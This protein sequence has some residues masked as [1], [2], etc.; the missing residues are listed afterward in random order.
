MTRRQA[1]KAKC[2]DCSGDS[3]MEVTLCQVL[4]CP[5][6]E[7]RLGQDTDSPVH[8]RRV[9]KVMER[10]PDIYAEYGDFYKN[11]GVL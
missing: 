10:N 6:W 4:K 3:A 7:W 11:K 5:L 1:I 9:K 2:L 8:H